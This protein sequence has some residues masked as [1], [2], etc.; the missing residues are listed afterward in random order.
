M[1]EETEREREKE[2]V[3]VIVTD[4]DPGKFGK[5]VE[6]HARALMICAADDNFLFYHRAMCV[7]TLLSSLQPRRRHIVANAGCRLCMFPVIRKTDCAV[8]ASTFCLRKSLHISSA[9]ISSCLAVTVD[10]A[11]IR[12]PA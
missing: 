9:V 4:S 10:D 6:I 2:K 11:L 3:Y 1:Q 8:V 12:R 7:I 5:C